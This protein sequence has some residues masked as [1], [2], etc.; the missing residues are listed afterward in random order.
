MAVAAGGGQ[1]GGFRS[2]TLNV[3]GILSLKY[4]L[5]KRDFSREFTETLELKSEVLN[6][7]KLNTSLSF[8]PNDSS[9]TICLIH[10]TKRA[11]EMLIL[12][13][14]QG[15]DVSS[16]SACTAGSVEPSHV[17]LAMGYDEKAR[18]SIRISLG[19]LSVKQKD[20]VLNKLET[21]LRKL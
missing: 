13:D 11:D 20:T 17:L 16:G 3:H 14:M 21:V 5:E 9:N 2:G 4:A 19:Y 8:I 1:Q 12:F 7:I 10:E 18:N 6:L 15:V